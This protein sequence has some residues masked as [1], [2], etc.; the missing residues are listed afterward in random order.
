M[1]VKFNF[2]PAPGFTFTLV[3]KKSNNGP[4]ISEATG[5]KIF[6]TGLRRNGVIADVLVRLEDPAHP[7][8]TW[9]FNSSKTNDDGVSFREFF[10]MG[11][12]LR[13]RGFY[14]D[15]DLD[16]FATFAGVCVSIAASGSFDIEEPE[17]S[18]PLEPR[19]IYA[20]EHEMLNGEIPYSCPFGKNF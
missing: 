19:L 11:G 6:V 9:T 4:S 17:W 20:T 7:D 16:W 15:E 2:T 14:G 3:A 1:M 10:T 12:A 13:A 8:R 18:I 5:K